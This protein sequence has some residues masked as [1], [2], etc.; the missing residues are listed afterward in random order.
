M[1]DGPY[2][3]I[4]E[5]VTLG[6]NIKFAG[7]A[8]LYGCEIGNDCIIGPFVEIQ[9]G[10]KVGNQVK[11]QSHSFICTGVEIHDGVFIGH[12]VMFVNDRFPRSTLKEG[13]LKG[14]RDWECES[15]VIGSRASIGTNATILC[16]VRIGESAIIGAGSVVTKNVPSGAIVAGNPAKILRY[17]EK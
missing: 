2:I 5:D 3:T 1:K 8:N 16:G 13:G 15:T 9:K 17:I 12:S 14:P 4:S 7:Y 6:T 10:V 11:I